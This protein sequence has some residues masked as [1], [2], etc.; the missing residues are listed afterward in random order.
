VQK[1]IEIKFRRAV[2]DAE[3]IQIAELQLCRRPTDRRA[4]RRTSS[5]NSY[6]FGIDWLVVNYKRT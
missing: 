2:T 1:I 4:G 3:D 6:L 5:R